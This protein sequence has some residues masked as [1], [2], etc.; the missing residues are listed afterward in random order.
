MPAS[1]PRA[2]PALVQLNAITSQDLSP[3][4]DAVRCRCCCR[5]IPQATSKT[6]P[7]A[8]RRLS[9]SRYQADF[10]PADLFD[11]GPAGYDA[12][13]S[14]RARRRRRP[15]VADLR[16]AGRSADHRLDP[17]LRPRR[18]ARRQG[19]AG[20]GAGGAIPRHAPLHPRRL[21]ALR[22]HAL[23][24]ALCGVDPVSRLGAARAAAGL[25]RG[26]SHRR[27][28]SESPAHRRRPTGAAAV[29]HFLRDRRTAGGGFARLHLSSGRRHHRPQ[30]RAQARRTRRLR[31][32]FANPFSAGESPGRHPLA[33][34][35][36]A[37]IREPA[38]ASIRGGTIF[39]KPAASR[40]GNAP[41]ASAIRARTS[42]PRPARRT[43][44]ATAVA[45]RG[46]RPSSPSA[47]AS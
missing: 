43:A 41:P 3:G 45:I 16:Q 9:L 22:L 23:R 6:R 7:T 33:I 27:A 14:L 11:A 2:T 5:S 32:L 20:Q 24:R 25:P 19:R 10:R 31:R 13:F 8:R 1:D 47:T 36:Q 28:L 37:K 44:T 38:A 34:L 17:D 39:A 4:S 21:C 35:R 15:A 18:S 40:S 26:L 42:A 46:S 29:R 12:V 30:R